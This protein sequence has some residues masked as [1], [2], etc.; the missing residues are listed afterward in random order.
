MFPVFFSALLHQ[1]ARVELFF[2]TTTMLLLWVENP[3]IHLQTH[4]KLA[5]FYLLY[6]LQL[7]TLFHFLR[8]SS[9]VHPVCYLHA[10]APWRSELSI[11]LPPNSGTL[12]PLILEHW[13]NCWFLNRESKLIWSTQ[14]YWDIII[15][16]II[17]THGKMLE[18]LE[19][20]FEMEDDKSHNTAIHFSYLIEKS[21]FGDL[22]NHSWLSNTQIWSDP[23]L[24]VLHYIF[25][26]CFTSNIW[27]WHKND[28]SN[29]EFNAK[30]WLCC[31]KSNFNLKILIST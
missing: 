2:G 30:F 20:T 21:E 9:I 7:S 14:P 3:S 11:V 18:A 6:I 29:S 26:K 23:C 25:M 12:C 22:N 16:I 4:H 31:H 17:I 19:T 10:S 1:S 15:I 8:S 5:P 24:T 13:L 28:C 27:L